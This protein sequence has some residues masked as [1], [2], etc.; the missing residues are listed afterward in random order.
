MSLQQPASEF[1]WAFVR[2]ELLETSLV[3]KALLLDFVAYTVK[4]SGLSA[5][6]VVQSFQ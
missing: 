2:A 3:T 4:A 1:I 5:L 6:H